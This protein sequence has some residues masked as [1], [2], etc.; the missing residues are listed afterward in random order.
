MCVSQ[1]AKLSYPRMVCGPASC[2]Q[3]SMAKA[4]GKLM[5]GWLDQIGNGAIGNQT[6]SLVP[7]LTQTC[8]SGHV[9]LHSLASLLSTTYTLRIV[10]CVWLHYQSTQFTSSLASPPLER[11]PS[12]SSSSRDALP[13]LPR[14][15]LIQT[16]YNGHRGGAV[17]EPSSSRCG[18]PLM[19][20]LERLGHNLSRTAEIS[21][22]LV[23]KRLRGPFP[24]SA[25]R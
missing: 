22:A 21:N 8:Q 14:A 18:P 6:A 4:Q 17:W 24:S 13:L 25:H 11:W 10:A 2:Q 9:H 3:T 5:P 1:L 7:S 12:T 23:M 20:A 15:P 16:P 19:K